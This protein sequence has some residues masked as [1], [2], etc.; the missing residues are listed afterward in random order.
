M[1]DCGYE[2]LIVLIVL[3][4]VEVLFV[5]GDGEFG[6]DGVVDGLEFGV[7]ALDEGFGLGF[8]IER[9]LLG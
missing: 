2:V 9:H 1:D 3:V 4:E 8:E 5:A 7:E 6:L